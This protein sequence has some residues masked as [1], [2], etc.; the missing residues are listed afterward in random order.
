[1]LGAVL[2][3]SFKQLTNKGSF[4][5]ITCKI[6]LNLSFDKQTLVPPVN[7]W[8]KTV[9]LIYYLN[10]LAC[11]YQETNQ[12]AK[13]LVIYHG[14]L[15]SLKSNYEHAPLF[16]ASLL[17]NMALIYIKQRHYNKAISLLR[18]ALD[19]DSKHA[20]VRSPANASTLNNLAKVYELTGQ[21]LKALILYNQALT[22]LENFLGVNHAETA[23]VRENYERLLLISFNDKLLD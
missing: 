4:Y 19:I 14:L 5:A 22:I 10:D 23:K 13:A 21:Y 2:L 15:L 8:N 16:V 17:N 3:T 6:K 11:F 12:T 9:G 1:M 20:L 7:G 18:R